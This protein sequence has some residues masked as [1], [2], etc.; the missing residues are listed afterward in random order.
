MKQEKKRGIKKS[1]RKQAYIN[2]TKK[3]GKNLRKKI[4]FFFFDNF[5]AQ[6]FYV[7]FFEQIFFNK[8]KRRKKNF[9]FL[10]NKHT[11]TQTTQQNKTKEKIHSKKKSKTNQKLFIKAIISEEISYSF[12]ICSDVL[13][14]DY[15]NYSH[16][17]YDV[18]LLILKKK[19]MKYY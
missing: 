19:L 18:Q 10:Y 7:H 2:N 5:S 11:Y 6:H 17:K 12:H 15:T 8:L 3:N 14:L 13:I 4:T 16:Q 9:F 1:C